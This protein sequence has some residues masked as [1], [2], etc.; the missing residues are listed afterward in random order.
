MSSCL[1]YFVQDLE[2]W[3]PMN[4]SFSIHIYTHIM[5]I[6]ANTCNGRKVQVEKRSIEVSALIRGY[7]V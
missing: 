7:G 5:L 1:I 3:Q 4:H 6:I 2:E